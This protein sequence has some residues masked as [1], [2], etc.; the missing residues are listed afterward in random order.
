MTYTAREVAEL[1][2]SEVYKLH[3]LPT[4]IVSD[5]DVLF[6]SGFWTHFQKLIGAKQKC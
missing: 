4:A 1:V 5:Q 2:F 6:M 3:G